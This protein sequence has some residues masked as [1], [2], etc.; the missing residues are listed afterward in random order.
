MFLDTSVDRAQWQMYCKC[1]QCQ[2]SIK[3]SASADAPINWPGSAL[4]CALN[5]LARMLDYYFLTVN[6]YVFFKAICQ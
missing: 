5:L 4:A 3:C 1:I 2:I 6:A